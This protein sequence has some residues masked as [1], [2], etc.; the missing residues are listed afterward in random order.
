MNDREKWRERVRD[1]RAGGASWW[2]WW[3]VKT[4]QFQTTQFNI[5]TLWNMWK[6]FY[7]KLFSLEWIHLISIWFIEWALSV[8]TIPR[9]SGIGNKRNERVLRSPQSFSITGASSSVAL[10][11]VV[12]TLCRD[13]IGVFSIPIRLGYCK[14]AV[15]TIINEIDLCMSIYTW[16][17][18]EANLEERVWVRVKVRISKLIK[19]PPRLDQWSDNTQRVLQSQFLKLIIFNL[20]ASL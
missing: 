15:N 2:W 12:L 4:F 20:L 9:Q 1:I 10:I 11:E 18:Q 13:A 6:Q 8:T 16:K 17:L 5:S 3:N 14:V 7:F 19:I